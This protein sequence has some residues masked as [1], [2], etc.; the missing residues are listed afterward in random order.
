MKSLVWV[1]PTY[2]VTLL[3][4][5][6]VFVHSV[7]LF[8]NALS[9]CKVYFESQPT[10]QMCGMSISTTAMSMRTI[11]LIRIMFVVSA[12]EKICKI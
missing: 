11:S 6:Y 10:L 5:R 1:C 4:L 8:R 3:P 12:D 2:P 7:T 9:K